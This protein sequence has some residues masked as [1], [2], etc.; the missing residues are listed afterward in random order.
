MTV[1][2]TSIEINDDIK[3]LILDMGKK[4][5]QRLRDKIIH[6]ILMIQNDI[7]KEFGKNRMPDNFALGV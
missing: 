3:I 2:K 7:R 6:N 5:G 4:Y 1:N